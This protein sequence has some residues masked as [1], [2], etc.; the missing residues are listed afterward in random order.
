[1]SVARDRLL[2]HDA[3]RRVLDAI[4]RVK[5]CG[6]ARRY[7]LGE[8]LREIF[9]ERRYASAL[10]RHRGILERGFAGSLKE[11]SR[12]RNLMDPR[13]SL[14]PAYEEDAATDHEDLRLCHSQGGLRN[15]P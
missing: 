4:A 12:G 1:M 10:K 13:C 9:L 3:V 5:S 2:L 15:N 7:I 6:G 11:A 14:E 8:T